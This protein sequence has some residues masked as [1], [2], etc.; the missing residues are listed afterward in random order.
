MLSASEFTVGSI[1]QATPLALVL[2]RHDHEETILIARCESGPAAFFLSERERFKWFESSGN[3]HWHGLIIPNVR[4]E[5][6]ESSI[7][8]PSRMDE[9][10]GT[11]IRSRDRLV[12]K[13]KGLRAFSMLES[14]ILEDSLTPTSQEHAGFL[15]WQVVIGTGVEK[16]VLSSVS[17]DN[18]K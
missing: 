6:D 16:R 12:V 14:L 13:A 11:V 1:G 7:F 9:R 5:V 18:P 2:P 8:D 3:E 15:R 4:I 17:A 10:P